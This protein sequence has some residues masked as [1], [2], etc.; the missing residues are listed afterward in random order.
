M[1]F[2]FGFYFM[3]PECVLYV[4]TQCCSLKRKSMLV[5]IGKMHLANRGT[6]LGRVVVPAWFQKP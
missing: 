1:S 3:V 4:G 5:R 6:Q 2:L